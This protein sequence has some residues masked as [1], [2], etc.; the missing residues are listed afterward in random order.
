MKRT[1][2]VSKDLKPLQRQFQLWRKNHPNG[3]RLPEELWKSAVKLTSDLSV[4]RVS[5]ALGLDYYKLKERATNT[6]Q[7]SLAMTPCSNFVEVQLDP[8]PQRTGCLIQMVNPSGAQM[9]IHLI[10][11]KR[12]ELNDVVQTFCRS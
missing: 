7:S 3:N 6:H 9:T 1:K 11:G 12:G 5:R 4:S 10:Q 2:P 8:P